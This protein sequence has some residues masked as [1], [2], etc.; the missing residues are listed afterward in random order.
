MARVRRPE[1]DEY[2]PR[3]GHVITFDTTEIEKQGTELRIV[4]KRR[5]G[6]CLRK[7]PGNYQRFLV[8]GISSQVRLFIEGFDE[9]VNR[10]D[11]NLLNLKSDRSVIRLG[12]LGWVPISDIKHSIGSISE[13]RH[14]R[15]LERLSKYLVQ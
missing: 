6:I 12:F 4:I 13:Q 14:R 10:S 8:C 11:D 2:T 9:I 15:L 1:A 5:P 3:P 7:L